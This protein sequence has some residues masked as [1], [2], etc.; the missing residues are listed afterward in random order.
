MY[1]K[2]PG[3]S[4]QGGG[5]GGGP[6]PTGGAEGMQPNQTGVFGSGIPTTG[7]STISSPVDVFS[8][9]SSS[10]G[11]VS[12]GNLHGQTYPGTAYNNPDL[13]E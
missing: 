3:E 12:G 5:S 2:N 13:R 6:A 8:T 1:G 11:V 10:A 9:L 4:F 7:Q